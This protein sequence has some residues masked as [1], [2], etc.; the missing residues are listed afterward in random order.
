MGKY[1]E[2]PHI[3]EILFDE[4]MKPLRLSQNALAKAIKVPS[5]RINAIVN[6]TRGI[7][8]DT[9]LR[10]TKYFSLTAGYFLRLQA[11]LDLIESKRK[12][13]DDLTSIIPIKTTEH[14]KRIAL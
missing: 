12:I 14:E 6:G 7:T 11:N 4:F 9:D 2:V 8:A 5:N 1:I 10:L 3:G 13:K